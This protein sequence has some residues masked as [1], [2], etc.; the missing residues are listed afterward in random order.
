MLKLR[1]DNPASVLVYISP[2]FFQTG[3]GNV[4]LRKKADKKQIQTKNKQKLFHGYLI[5]WFIAGH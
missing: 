3:S 2:F 4:M 1:I 5:L